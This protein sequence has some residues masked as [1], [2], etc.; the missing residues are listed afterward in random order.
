RNAEDAHAAAERAN[1]QYQNSLF[2]RMIAIMGEL[3]AAGP[4][5]AA[6]AYLQGNPDITKAISKGYDGG[7]GSTDIGVIADAHWQDH[8]R[9]ENREVGLKPQTRGEKYLANNPDVLAGI[10]AG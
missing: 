3:R 5:T 7:T 4:A 6:A 1:Q 9:F 10:L 2:E 8:G